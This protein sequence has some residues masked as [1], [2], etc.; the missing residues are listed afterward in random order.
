MSDSFNVNDTVWVKLTAAGVD[1]Y[2]KHRDELLTLL[3]YDP[4]NDFMRV[5][6]IGEAKSFQMHDLM[7]TFGEMMTVGGAVPFECLVYFREPTP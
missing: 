4:G 1:C 6:G 5:P 3:P 7:H 2:R